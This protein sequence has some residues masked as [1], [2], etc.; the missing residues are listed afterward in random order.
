M[1]HLFFTVLIFT[2]TTHSFG[3]L[4]NESS[5]KA[6]YLEN[7]REIA[8]Q[9]M[10]KYGIPASITIAQGML[11][12]GYGE[13]ALAKKSNNHFG[14][15]CHSDWSGATTYANDD[16]PNECFRVYASVADSYEDHSLFLTNNKRYASLFLLD[17]K[18]YKGWA[19]GLKTAGYAT[20]PTYATILISLIEESS[21]QQLD[22]QGLSFVSTGSNSLLIQVHENKVRYVKAQ[23]GDTYYKIAQRAGVTLNQLKRYNESFQGKDVLK[24]GDKVYLDPRRYRSKTKKS[25]T[26]S[27]SI[28]LREIA[29]Q[30]AIKLKPLMRRNPGF[31][32]DEQL[33]RGKEIRLR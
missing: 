14:I 18:D 32:A 24:E 5:K 11:E 27:Q 23:K 22:Q 20:S 2:L 19:E 9:Q 33:P 13:S 21:L 16:K 26:L 17:K 3:A 8:V 30:E 29:Q 4:D 28:S 6:L 12:S 7:Y 31:T 25:I 1:R 15:K 10:N